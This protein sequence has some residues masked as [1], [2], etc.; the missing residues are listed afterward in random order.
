MHPSPPDSD[1]TRPGP[2]LATQY[3]TVLA[4]AP[5]GAEENGDRLMAAVEAVVRERE[6]SPLA[7]Y[8]G[9]PFCAYKCHFCDWV[10]DVPSAV[11]RSDEPRR[12]PYVAA[13]C[14]Q[15]RYYGSQLS[16]MGYVPTFMYWGGG[17]PTRLSVRQLREVYDAVADSFDLSTIEQWSVETTPND[18]T[19]EK[20]DLLVSVGVSRISL[21]VQSLNPEQLRRSG[22]GHTPDEAEAAI[23]RLKAT[24]PGS[25]NVDVMTGFPDEE[26][27]WTDRIVSR[28][29]EYDTPSITLYPF[30]TS[31][32]TVVERQVRAGQLAPPTLEHHLASYGRAARL[33]ES[34]GYSPGKHHGAWRRDERHED[35]DGNY[36]YQLMGDKIG[37][38]SGAA[39]IVGHRL[40]W[41]PGSRMAEF[42]ADP[43][44][45]SSV[46]KF[47]LAS[48]EMFTNLVGGAQMAFADGLV[49][50]RFETLTGV[51]FQAF[52]QIPWTKRIF[53]YLEGCGGRFIETAESIRLDPSC[54]DRV[55][56]AHQAN[57][58]A[59]MLAQAGA[60]THS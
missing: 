35:K 36:K 44:R 3:V 2:D 58:N 46:Q 9:V 16:A 18:L 54:I 43:L 57:V 24:G 26:L 40:L 29:V 19:P 12:A 7:I 38:G 47:S 21:G 15:I 8:V 56:L 52:R 17:T 60:G 50:K 39:S 23:R 41:N 55:V 20:L 30:R 14:R 49:F 6:R 34:A 25:F 27:E 33:L 22:R 10:A 37:F 45:F 48:P 5:I 31:V 53:A 11:L 13:L 32:N 4:R 51:P 1:S 59:D 28:L 42:V